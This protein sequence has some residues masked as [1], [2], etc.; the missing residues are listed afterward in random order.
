MVDVLISIAAKVAEYTVE[1]ICRQLGYLF[2]YQKSVEDL[3]TKIGDLKNVRE[4]LQHEVG[5]AQRSGENIFDD[6][7]EWVTKFDKIITED[8]GNFTRDEEA[9]NS[10]FTCAAKFPNLVLRHRLSRRAK[11]MAEKVT[12][13][14]QDREKIKKVSYRPDLQNSVENKDYEEFESRSQTM[15]DIIE[16]LKVPSVAMVGVWGM[17]GVG[18]TM[19]AKEVPRR[20]IDE[21]KLFTKFIF[22]TVSKNQNIGKIQQDIAEYLG[23]KLDEENKYIRAARLRNRLTQENKILII[24]D[25]I[26]DK[27]DLEDVISFGIHHRG[28]KILLTTRCFHV[29]ANDMGVDRN[30]IFAVGHLLEHEAMSLFRKITGDQAEKD[31]DFQ[32]LE[33]KIVKECGG[34]PIAITTVASALK[35]QDRAVWK[36][37]LHELRKSNP[38]NIPDMHEKVYKSIKFSYDYLGSV[39]AKHLLLLCSLFPEDAKIKI[40]ELCIYG[41]GLNLFEN[42]NTLEEARNRTDTLAANLKHRS[43]LL[44]GGVDYSGHDCV[45]LH[46]IIR[47]VVIFIVSKLDDHPRMH[48]IRDVVELDKY[49]N[50]EKSKESTAMSVYGI[51]ADQYPQTLKTPKLKL[52]RLESGYDK[53]DTGKLP[54]QFFEGLKK[55][56]VLDSTG[57]SLE[58]L[59]AAAASSF[60]LLPNLTTLRLKCLTRLEE[61]NLGSFRNWQVEGP[62]NDDERRNASL[63]EVKNLSHLID[64]KLR[65]SDINSLPKD[66]F[67]QECKL[68]KY[69]ICIGDEQPGWEHQN[70]SRILKLK[71]RP[72]SELNE[73]DIEALLKKSESLDLCGLKSVKSI[74]FEIDSMG[75]KYLKHLSVQDSAE[76]RC[77]VNSNN[78][79]MDCLPAAF[80]SLESLFLRRLM[81]LENIIQ[82]KPTTETSFEKLRM[83]EVRTCPKMKS[84]FSLY[85]ILRQLENIFVYDCEMME[86]IISHH[87][88]EGVLPNIMEEMISQLRVLKLFELPK[89][90]Q[91]IGASDKQSLDDSV[92]PLFN[93]QVVFSKLEELHISSLNIRKI[94]NHDQLPSSRLSFQSLTRIE[95]SSCHHLKGLMPSF[96]ITYLVHLRSLF[97]NHCRAMKEIVVIEE[98]A[99]VMTNCISFSKLEYLKLDDLPNLER[100]CGGDC[101]DCP[102]L[103]QLIIEGCQRLRVFRTNAM[104]NE[105]ENSTGL[106]DQQHLFHHKVL[107]PKLEELYIISLL[108]IQKIWN[109]DQLPTSWFGFQSL[110]TIELWSCDHL[111]GVIPSYMTASLVH[112][113]RLSVKHCEAMKEIVFVEEST[114]VMANYISF[115]K[116]KYLELDCLPNLERFCGGDCVDCPSL[117]QLLIRGCPRLR[118]FKTNAMQIE[119]ENS[120]PTI[121]V[122]KQLLSHHKDAVKDELNTESSCSEI[123][124][125]PQPLGP[126]EEHHDM[127]FKTKRL[128][129]L[130]LWNF[131]DL[132]Q[133]PKAKTFQTVESLSICELG[134]RIKDLATPLMCFQNLK[135]F[136][137]KDCQGLTSLLSPSTAKSL[138]QRLTILGISGCKSLRQVIAN[139]QKEADDDDD[140]IRAHTINIIFSKLESL[141]LDDLSSLTSFYSGNSN[142]VLQFP[143]L[144]KLVVSDCPEMKT[145]YHGNIDCPS[146]QGIISWSFQHYIRDMMW[147]PEY[148]DLGNCEHFDW[149]GDVNTTIQK[150]WEEEYYKR[151]TRK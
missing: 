48:N 46:D 27:L 26:W 110:T 148:Y 4:R 75:F 25:D 126:V 78:G 108:N 80:P 132:Q 150:L 16:A 3:N 138:S 38:T 136:M 128:S 56:L 10:K 107:F 42:V 47:D 94:W 102:S 120:T 5:E 118:L 77:I 73:H 125:Q 123:T 61:L 12:A 23:M 144:N 131:P 86:E 135:V 62:I 129:E 60:C 139:D 84:L 7:N 28:C 53:K 59:P 58:P 134:V 76:I 30:V 145:F 52:L 39:E 31:D 121:S 41:F 1:P 14:M 51:E 66:M 49:A 122:D 104:Q 21:E 96:M 29:L 81:N 32:G 103:S 89:L 79:N 18:K 13:Q 106:V 119:N 11:K 151:C 95:V 99:Q 105:D 98:S 33:A 67:R 45:K 87:G 100:F 141:I 71:L 147:Y 127:V 20:V 22:I 130:R 34:L 43:L 74:A 35:N 124:C 101:V 24:V 37:A 116:L 146:L 97:V 114:Q 83:I 72:G 64:L 19:L 55:L 2:S 70:A 142:V 63:S 57:V 9:A 90:V 93:G 111:K 8:L 65:V 85:N 112:L 149:K 68:V 140:E 88:R 117:S 36:N 69:D 17:G 109:D 92:A 50:E 137:I 143:H 15:K 113:R 115:S 44:D 82:E 40:R 133:L 91:F 6:V 54:P